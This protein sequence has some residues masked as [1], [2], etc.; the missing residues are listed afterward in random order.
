MNDASR[1]SINRKP[2]LSTK[3]AGDAASSGGLRFAGT[4]DDAK[5]ASRRANPNRKAFMGTCQESQR[6]H[7]IGGTLMNGRVA[8]EAQKTSCMPR[9]GRR[10]RAPLPPK[11]KLVKQFRLLPEMEDEIAHVGLTEAD[12]K[13]LHQRFETISIE[14]NT[15]VRRADLLTVLGLPDAK[16]IYYHSMFDHLSR[17]ED[18]ETEMADLNDTSHYRDALTWPEFVHICIAICAFT[19]VDVM[20]FVFHVGVSHPAALELALTRGVCCRLTM[21]TRT[22]S[23]HHRNS[24]KSQERRIPGARTWRQHDWRSSC[25][26]ESTTSSC[27]SSSS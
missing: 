3:L 24:R 25:H 23:Y 22:G 11:G 1:N 20:T 26:R 16:C 9:C 8:P 4:D 15:I 14:S 21:P 18:A 13:K 5:F 7:A 6:A 2:P 19:E 12:M 17:D 10:A 27:P